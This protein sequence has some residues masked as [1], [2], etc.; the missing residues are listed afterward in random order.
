MH[1]QDEDIQYVSK[2][3]DKADDVDNDVS[4]ESDVD[5]EGFDIVD[6][7]DSESSEDEAPRLPSS[8]ENRFRNQEHPRRL[9]PELW[10]NVEGEVRLKARLRDTTGRL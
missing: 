5:L 3:L 1:D 6:V 7:Y 4:S 10:F 2:L 8:K 9:H